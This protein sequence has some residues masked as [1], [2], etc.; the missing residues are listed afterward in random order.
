[1]PDYNEIRHAEINW[2]I[3]LTLNNARPAAIFASVPLSVVRATYPDTSLLEIQRQLDYLE[4]RELVKIN[5]QPD[6]RWLCELTRLGI[7]I[8]EYRATVEPGIAR[9]EKYFDA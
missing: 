1:M 8:V 3:L 7:D 2:Q 4:K 9:P 5:R 6:G